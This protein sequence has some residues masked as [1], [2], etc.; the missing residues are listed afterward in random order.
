MAEEANTFYVVRK[1]D[2]FGVYQSLSDVQAQISSSVHDPSVR[3]YKG[4]VLKK[5]TEEYLAS[6]GLKDALYTANAADVNNDT[7][8]KLTPCPFTQPDGRTILADKGPQKV[9]SQHKSKM[10]V[11]NSRSCILEFDGASKGNPGK[12][13]AGVILRAQDGSVV[14]RIRQGLGFVTNNVA[15]Y[16]ALILGLNYA[17]SRGFMH[18]VVRGD[19]Q[20]VCMQVQGRWQ[21]KNQN[22]AELCKVVKQLKERFISFQIN[23]VL[24]EFNSDAD[25]EANKAVHLPAGEI[26]EDFS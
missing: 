5:E 9:S 20:L 18:I 3:V 26:R 2:I 12:S 24:R 23:H 6:H 17:L 11:N 22:M 4:Y 8:E 7:F 13:G 14:S 21:T 1:G 10:A 15:E 16:Q 19:S 25:A